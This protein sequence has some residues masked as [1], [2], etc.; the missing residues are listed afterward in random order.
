MKTI[1]APSGTYYYTIG[2][3]GAG[4][5]AGTSGT[6]GG[7]G[8]AGGV[9]IT[10]Y[11]TSSP[12]A[13]GNDYAEMFP[14]SSPGIN[15]GDIV[16]VDVGVPVSM[17]L[18]SQG[19]KALAGVISTDPGQVLGNINAVGMRPVAL[20]GRVPVKFSDE[21]GA[22]AAGDRIAPSSVPGVGMK[23]GPFDDSVGIVIDTNNGTRQGPALPQDQDTVMIFLDLH[24]GIDINAIALGLLGNDVFSSVATST[25]STTASASPLDFVGGMMS[26]IASRIDAFV[27]NDI[28]ASSSASTSSAA[29]STA[30][31]STIAATSTPV[32]PVDGYVQKLM[33]SIFAKMNVWLGYAGNGITEIFAKTI[34]AE[35]VYADTGTFNKVCVKKSDGGQVCVT[36]DELENILSN[37]GQAA[38]AAAGSGESAPQEEAPPPPEPEAEPPTDT[39]SE[40]ALPPDPEAETD[41]LAEDNSSTTSA[42]ETQVPPSEPAPEPAPVDQTTTETPAS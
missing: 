34:R 2:T 38:A 31:T 14:V 4:G 15:A 39:P 30:A 21:N 35:N 42:P 40:E 27:S 3:G 19:D 11:A 1:I 16:A 12:T 8:G 20:A 17:K 24:R 29:T 36:G 5:T 9:V 37:T 33:T 18:A 28:S 23:A 25:A 32:S 10:L 26:A 13:A 6:A 41:Q 7:A 22:V